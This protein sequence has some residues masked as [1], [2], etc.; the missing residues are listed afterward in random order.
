MTSRKNLFW[1]LPLCVGLISASDEQ[2]P[3]AQ[4]LLDAVHKVSDLSSLSSYVLTGR[5]VVNPGDAK[6]E[7]VGT[8]TISRDHDLSRVELKISGKDEVQIGR[9]KVR[10]IVPSQ[11]LLPASGLIGLDK[12]WDPLTQNDLESGDKYKLGTA[13]AESIDGQKAWCFFKKTSYMKVT[14]TE[15]LCMDAT[16]PLLLL[17]KFDKK[18]QKVFMDYAE[19]GTQK[20]P[21][22][23]SIIRE[24]MAPVE[25][26]EIHVAPATLSE[27]LFKPPENAIE[28]ETCVNEHYPEPKRTPE[29]AFPARASKESRHGM[30]VLNVIVAKDGTIALARS[31]T[32][33]EYGFSESAERTVR[34]WQFK[35]ATCNGRPIATEMNIEVSFDRI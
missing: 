3:S 33:D 34:T 31:I 15:Q 26:R 1:I 12:T 11:T 20:Y 5:V 23:V 29:P 2:V 21:Q 8:L 7:Q 14:S 16:R 22:K 13:H 17:T 24:R 30:V 10:F 25:V 35:P 28:V 4:E 19:S 6:R 27:D 9:N 18:N 32:P